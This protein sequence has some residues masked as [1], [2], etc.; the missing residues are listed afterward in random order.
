MTEIITLDEVLD[1]INIGL[2]D[3]GD[4][5]T[6]IYNIKLIHEYFI[7]REYLS[8]EIKNKLL[9]QCNKLIVKYIDHDNREVKDI[10]VEFKNMIIQ[11]LILNNDD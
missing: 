3:I 4:R 10:W 5:E 2:L 11:K 8:Y 1:Y 7:S 9:K 6:Y